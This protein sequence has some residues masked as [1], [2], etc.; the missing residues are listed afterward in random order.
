MKHTTATQRNGPRCSQRQLHP[1]PAVRPRDQHEALDGNEQLQ[2]FYSAVHY[3]DSVN[4]QNALERNGGSSQR[5]SCQATHGKDTRR[6]VPP[7]KIIIPEP[8]TYILRAQPVRPRGHILATVYDRPHSR[9]HL[10]TTP[11]DYTRRTGGDLLHGERVGLPGACYC[12]RNTRSPLTS[13]DERGSAIRLREHDDHLMRSP[14]NYLWRETRST[15][16]FTCTSRS[17]SH[18][19]ADK[20]TSA[21]TADQEFVA[22]P[23]RL[24]NGCRN[25]GNHQPRRHFKDQRKF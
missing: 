13:D 4:T 23:P 19:A 15:Q 2:H 3:E 9:Y 20:G 21:T 1:L 7:T 25:Y 8:E 5:C 12:K 24:R 6:Q 17:V 14:P 11:A 18:Y 16:D 22:S 10:H